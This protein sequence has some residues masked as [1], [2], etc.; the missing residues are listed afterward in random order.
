[1]TPKEDMLDESAQLINEI[2]SNLEKVLQKRKEEVELDLQL[3]MRREKEDAERKKTLIEGEFEKERGT[4]KEFRGAI[5]EFETARKTLQDRMRDHLERGMRYQGDIEKLTALTL[6]ELRKVGDLSLQLSDLRQTSEKKVAEI[7]T[8]LK[9]RFG[10]ALEASAAVPVPAPPPAFERREES[11][12]ASDLDQELTRLKKIKELLETDSIGP[13]RPA[14]ERAPVRE[15]FAEPLAVPEEPEFVPPERFEPLSFEPE[16]P[17]AEFKMPEINQFIDDFMKRESPSQPEPMF[18]ES[19][20]VKKEARK[21]GL[22]DLSFQA[23]FETLEKYRKTEP[24]DFNGEISYF[25]NRERLILDGE[26]LI[27]AMSQ[28]LENAKKQTQKLSQT[29]SPKDQFFLK[30][31][32]INQQ[33]SLRKILLRWVRLG[34]K[35]GGTLPRYTNEIISLPV[36]KDILEKLNMDNWSNPED[37]RSFESLTVRLKDAFYRKITPPAYYLRS[38]IEELEG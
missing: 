25:Q 35:D 36:L 34:E 21:Q 7:R 4:I 14:F 31:E 30:Q 17:R 29:E 15:A 13:D 20:P 18:R 12:M 24:L 19:A 10:I 1:M 11:A 37:V 23:V 3:K 9:E 38:I 32:L 16:K 33:E 6:E 27:R 2:E 22:D 26:S 28:V 5:S 8:K